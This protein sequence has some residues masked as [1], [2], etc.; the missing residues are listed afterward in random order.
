MRPVP[1]ATKYE[2]FAI[3]Q[4]HLMLF[5]WFQL[6]EIGLEMTF[7]LDR[8]MASDVEKLIQEAGDFQ[9][10]AVKHRCSV[11]CVCYCFIPCH[12]SCFTICRKT[13]GVQSII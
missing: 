5:Q 12:V 10:E 7:I 9:M 8:L 4:I 2:H 11:F 13:N 6:S 3:Y 1:I